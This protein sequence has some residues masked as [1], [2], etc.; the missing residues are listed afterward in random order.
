MLDNRRTVSLLLL[1]SD[2]NRTPIRMNAYV[3]TMRRYFKFKG[4]SSRA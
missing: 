1:N 4:R 3:D 2:T